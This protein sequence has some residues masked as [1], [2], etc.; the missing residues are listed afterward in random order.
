MI[1]TP[2]VFLPPVALILP[3]V[4][5]FLLY[6]SFKTRK[7]R[8]LGGTQNQKKTRAKSAKPAYSAAKKIRLHSGKT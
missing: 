3:R 6:Y 5:I 4:N 8:V 1:D 7:I 2:S